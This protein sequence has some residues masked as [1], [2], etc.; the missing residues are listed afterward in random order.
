MT[1]T[2]CES[3]VGNIS[4]QCAIAAGLLDAY[5]RNKKTRLE[6]ALKES[7]APDLLHLIQAAANDWLDG[8]STV[9]K[10]DV[11]ILVTVYDAYIRA[12]VGESY[13]KA[14]LNTFLNARSNIYA[15]NFGISYVCSEVESK[16]LEIIKTYYAG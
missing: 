9:M 2:T 10:V 12:A 3:L 16:I 7:T 6:M 15:D 4:Q 14:E 1:S 11:M 13:T 8:V 5:F